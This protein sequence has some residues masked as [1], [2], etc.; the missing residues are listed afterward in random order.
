M[1]ILVPKRASQKLRQVPGIFGSEIWSQILDHLSLVQLYRLS[2][3]SSNFNRLVFDES[4]WIAKFKLMEV[5]N[6]S[7]AEIL[8]EQYKAKEAEFKRNQEAEDLLGRK[9]QVAVEE[10][11]DDFGQFHEAYT[12]EII[13][14]RRKQ[15][16]L[17]LDLADTVSQ[18]ARNGP[19]LSIVKDAKPP[20]LSKYLT[21]LSEF[22]SNPMTARLDFASIYLVLSPIYKDL[23]QVSR[24]SDSLLYRYF[25]TPEDQAKALKVQHTFG[26][27]KCFENWHRKQG[28]VESMIQTFEAS[29]LREFEVGYDARDTKGK[30]NTYARILAELN[31]GGGSVQM[32]I[33]KSLL[34][35]ESETFV[36]RSPEPF[37][38][39][40]TDLRPLEY[41]VDHLVSELTAQTYIIQDAF[42]TSFKVEY[43]LIETVVNKRL[44]RFA[45]DFVDIM[46]KNRPIETYLSIY[47]RTYTECSRIATEIPLLQSLPSSTE[48]VNAVVDGIFDTTLPEYFDR[49][50]RMFQRFGDDLFETWERGS[51]KDSLTTQTYA[52]PASRMSFIRGFKRM[53]FKAPSSPSQTEKLSEEADIT[54][55]SANGTSP[56]LGL[57]EQSN[58]NGTKNASYLSLELALELVNRAKE[59]TDRVLLFIHISGAGGTQA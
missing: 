52:S 3:V 43:K 38:N 40:A 5:W 46:L 47:A 28:E 30:M 42:P 1:D 58:F 11:E 57:T 37:Q 41:Y 4:R 23:T 2:T 39:L 22:N 18:P 24:F 48:S 16:S 12:E 51:R 31:G 6:E 13:G 32:F 21:I 54:D 44:A 36:S 33:Q 45:Y 55:K 35:T 27:S 10:E 17:L 59:A 56:R 34:L 29:A 26:K 15:S 53:I 14:A 20:P 25:H 50:L 9:L 8:A 49:E 19:S 7:E